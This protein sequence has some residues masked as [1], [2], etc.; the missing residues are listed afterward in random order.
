MQLYFCQSSVKDLEDSWR[1]CVILLIFLSIS[2]SRGD[3][4]LLNK[5]LREEMF[6]PNRT[7]DSFPNQGFRNAAEILQFK[8]AN[9]QNRETCDEIIFIQG[10]FKHKKATELQPRLINH[11][12]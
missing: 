11:K 8:S 9:Y 5:D 1:I 3:L 4:S 7:E 2:T 12:P 10:K 6:M